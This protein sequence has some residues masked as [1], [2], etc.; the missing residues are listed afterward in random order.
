MGGLDE[1]LAELQ[2]LV[3]LGPVKEAV[4]VYVNVVTTQQLRRKAGLKV[5]S[6][7]HHLIFTGPPGTGKT[8]VARLLG[9]IF[10][11]LGLLEH[12]DVVEVARA[13][14]VAEYI[15]QTA[16]KTN[17]VINRALGGLLFIDEAYTLATGDRSND[18]GTEAIETLLKR[19]EDERDKFVVIAA[20]YNEPMKRFLDAN[21]GL[22]S[23]FDEIIEFPDYEPRDLALILAQFAASADYE[24]TA[25]ATD[26]AASVLEQAWRYRDAT[27]GNARLV[28][29]LF[30]D[31]T[32]A[33]AD[34]L[35]SG[36]A[37]DAAA[38]RRL[39]AVDIPN[40]A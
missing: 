37:P 26:K 22:R 32:R 20:G 5:W 25:D 18:F 12:G 40:T 8:T 30:E 13:D 23:R 14:L 34:R 7:S 35:A 1:A 29:N 9:K 2:G 39:E 11:A 24:L 31:T 27:F 19:M 36:S 17:Q 21:P 38:L 16:V 6:S 33:Q 3:G 4:R 28:R 10:R 15:G